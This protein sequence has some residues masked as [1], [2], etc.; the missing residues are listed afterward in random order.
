MTID[1]NHFTPWDALLGGLLIGLGAALL[2]LGTGRVAGVSG[3]FGKLVC[4]RAPDSGWRFAFLAG[5]VGSGVLWR[6]LGNPQGAFQQ[7]FETPGAWAVF[8]VAGLLAGFG[9][10]MANGCTSGHGVCGLARLSGRSLVAV[11]CFMLG[12][13]LAVY[14][15][16]HVLGG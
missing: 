1:F 9:A 15:I 16:R 3:I 12:G 6:L 4:D 11:P 14:L 13:G 7:G 8:S 10:R 2:F 5:L